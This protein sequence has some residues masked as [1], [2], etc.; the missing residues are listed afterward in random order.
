MQKRI[1]SRFPFS[2][3]LTA[4]LSRGLPENTRLTMTLVWPLWLLPIYLISQLLTPHPVWISL[5]TVT[6]L[7]YLLGYF[8][9]RS[10]AGLFRLERTR[11]GAILVAGDSFEEEFTFHNHSRLPVLWAEL[12]DQSDLPGYVGSRIAA[13][14]P[15]T[16]T[17]WRSKIECRQRGLFR[18]GPTTLRL[19]DPFSLFALE[20]RFAET[21]TVLIYPRVARLPQ[22]TLPRGNTSGTDR[23]RT[24]LFGVQP[25]A[26]V[27]EYQTG[28]SLRH[29]H[30]PTSAHRGAL[31]VKELELEPSGDVW[32]V[33]DLNARVQRGRPPHGTLDFAVMVAASLAA[34]LLDEGVSRA[35]GL[36]A[37]SG[38][39]GAEPITIELAPQQGRAQLWRIMAA[40]AP[41]QASDV[42]LAQLLHQSRGVLGRR[43]SLVVI[44]P[45][46]MANTDAADRSTGS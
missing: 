34:Q 5:L 8:W 27:R 7:I 35:V 26:S 16:F 28:D 33:L 20:T 13:V 43:R 31:A 23:R 11:K 29:I 32:I 9:L 38:Q 37:V 12:D 1:R 2:P 4:Y 25:S 14:G 40:L 46:A 6:T 45:D 10:Q 41:A 18:I 3:D 44:T 21:E 15:Q 30:W 22:L 36:L 42:P 17:R 24:S 39:D 19:A